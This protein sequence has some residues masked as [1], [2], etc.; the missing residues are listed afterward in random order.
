[1]LRNVHMTA[2]GAHPKQAANQSI[3]KLRNNEAQLGLLSS[4]QAKKQQL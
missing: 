1:M 2:A 4:N 3:E